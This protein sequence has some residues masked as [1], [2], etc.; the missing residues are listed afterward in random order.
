MPTGVSAP[1]TAIQSSPDSPQSNSLAVPV[2][3][4]PALGP[5]LSINQYRT[6]FGVLHTQCAGSALSPD[7]RSH[8]VIGG[9]LDDFARTADLEL[10]RTGCQDHYLVAKQER[11]I[12]IVGDKD[13][14]L[15]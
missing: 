3:H 12:N 10:L 8:E 13:Y 5:A 2:I 1:P 15:A 4:Q 6:M 9:V 11:F 14:G 7:E